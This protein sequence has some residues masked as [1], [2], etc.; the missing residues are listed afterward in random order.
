MLY[1]LC[2]VCCQGSPSIECP[3]ALY[4]MFGVCLKGFQV[5]SIPLLYT[6]RLVWFQGS[7]SIEY[8][9]VL[10]F[11]F[12]EYW[13]GQRNVLLVTQV[14]RTNGNQAK[15]GEQDGLTGISW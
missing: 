10:H 14:G 6:L 7:S 3:Y 4:F 15:E 11:L 8:L 1:A 12:G 13:F 5:Q 9:Y 2:W